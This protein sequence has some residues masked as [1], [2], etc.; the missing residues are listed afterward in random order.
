MGKEYKQTF[1]QREY[2]NGQQVYEKVLGITNHQEMAVEN[3]MRYLFTPV[4]MAVITHTKKQIASVD[5]DVE[6]GNPCM[7]LGGM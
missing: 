7:L 1:F 6:K 4:R 3:T 2:R 5:M